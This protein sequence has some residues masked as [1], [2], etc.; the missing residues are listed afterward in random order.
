MK[1]IMPKQ[2]IVLLCIVMLVT[3]PIV[4]AE[5]DTSTGTDPFINV[6]IPEFV[7]ERTITIAGTTRAMTRIDLYVNGNLERSSNR[8]AEGTFTFPYV[9]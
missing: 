4:I 9:R 6:E 2:I 8:N 3:L 1:K 7:S 5:N